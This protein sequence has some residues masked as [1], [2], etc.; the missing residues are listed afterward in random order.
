MKKFRNNSGFSLLE[1]SIVL[2]IMGF[3]ASGLLSFGI[4]QTAAS[5]NEYTRLHMEEIRRALASFAVAN[6]RLPCPMPGPV[7]PDEPGYGMEDTSGSCADTEI[8]ASGIHVGSVPFAAI[9]LPDEYMLDAWNHR[10]LY[11]VDSQFITSNGFLAT[12]PTNPPLGTINVMLSGDVT[13]GTRRTSTAAMVLVSFGANGYGAWPVQQAVGSVD[14]INPDPTTISISAAELE[15]AHIQHPANAPLSF[16]N[17]FSEEPISS[18]SDDIV[19]YAERWQLLKEGGGVIDQEYC[20]MVDLAIKGT[21]PNVT[22]QLGAIGCINTQDHY[23][24][25]SSCEERQKQM[26]ELLAQLC[27][28][29]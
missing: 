26:A 29:R 12:D 8:A 2:L 7:R 22:P 16:D 23:S 21:N 11:V 19:L 10:I 18:T 5:R 28:I 14:R 25:D 3:V 9:G 20:N 15:N 1:L 24:T 27:G 13:S 17:V 4:Y 6:S